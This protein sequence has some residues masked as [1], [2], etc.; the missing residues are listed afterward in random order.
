MTISLGYSQTFPLDFTDGTDVLT[1]FDG[2]AFSIITDEGNEVGQLVSVNQ[3][4]DTY[5]LTLAQTLNLSDN[6][7]NTITFRIKPIGDA[8]LTT[9]NHLLKFE[10]GTGGAA[11]TELGF[12]TTGN[13]WQTITLVQV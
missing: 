2:N 1:G 6:G 3:P 5:Q 8:G 10:Q 4:Y 9:R 7:N 12:T 13:D 11:Q